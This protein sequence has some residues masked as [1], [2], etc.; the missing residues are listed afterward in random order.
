MYERFPTAGASQGQMLD[1]PETPP[2]SVVNAARLM[3]VGAGLS[4]LVVIV[5]VATAGS[6][7]SSI[8]AKY[9]HYTAGQV[10]Q[11]EVGSIATLVL[12]GLIAIGLWLWMARANRMGRNWARI[13]AVVLFVF[14]T[15]N[16][17]GSFL[18]VHAVGTVITAGLVWLVGLGA[19]AFL[20]NR[21]S[22]AYF[23]RT[24]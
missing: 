17:L 2:R 9:P 12:F 21:E 6:L 5:S 22:A 15:L 1:G 20:F 24:R 16:L 7:R 14:N 23:G 13:V 8:L 18:Q 19:I 11:A 4:A 10:H 3:Y